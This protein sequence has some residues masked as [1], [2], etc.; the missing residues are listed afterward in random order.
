MEAT[1]AASD[2]IS[3]ATTFYAWVESALALE[4]DDDDED[5]SS[6]SDVTG[7]VNGHDVN[8]HDRSRVLGD[9][10]RASIA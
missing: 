3:A 10:T 6:S 9:A 1:R 5:E 7:H 4:D 2:A 8:G